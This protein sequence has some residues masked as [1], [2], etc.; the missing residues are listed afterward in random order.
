MITL[1]N[2]RNVLQGIRS[3]AVVL[4]TAVISPAWLSRPV[5]AAN[6]GPVTHT[7]DIAGFKFAPNPI[8]VSLGDTI[9]W[10]N[11]DIVPHTAT[12]SDDS[13]DTG[14]LPTNGEGSVT[15]TKG[16]TGTYFCRHHPGMTGTVLLS[17]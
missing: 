17:D 10:V 12:A 11:N 4:S 13:W 7:I 15:V 9:V 8:T 3:T 1:L 5:S 14:T 6:A 2:R 16:M